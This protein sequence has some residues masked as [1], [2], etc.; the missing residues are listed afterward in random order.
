MLSKLTGKI[1][2]DNQDYTWVKVEGEAVD[3]ISLGLFIARIHKGSRFFIEQVRLHDEVWLM[4]RFYVDVTARVLLL[5]NRAVQL[6]D[7]FSNYKRF[8]ATT[9]ILP[10]VREV[11][12]K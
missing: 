3:T 11:D 5:S 8:S 7:T 4:R 2:I 1:W 6:E 10:G 9:T 12:P